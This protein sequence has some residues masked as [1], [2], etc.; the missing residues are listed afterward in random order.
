VPA[1]RTAVMG[2]SRAPACELGGRAPVRGS[3]RRPP[4]PFQPS[5]RK[6]FPGT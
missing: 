6:L 5:L 1:L 2:A 3:G 4:R